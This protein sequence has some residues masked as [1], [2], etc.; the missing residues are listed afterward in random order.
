MTSK[1]YTGNIIT[2]TPTDPTGNSGAN[3]GVATGVWSLS[4]ARTFSAAG[5]WPIPASVPGAP[6]IGTATAGNATATVPFT[7]N[8]D[9]GGL[10]VT[11][12]T[13]TSNPG[14]ITGSASS[15]PITVTGLTNE[16][17]YT[18][19]VTATNAAGTSAASAASNSVT[20]ENPDRAVF[21][22]GQIL[23]GSYATNTMDYIDIKST[24]NATDFGD[25]SQVRGGGGAASSTTRALCMGGGD[26]FGASGSTNY[27]N[28][29]DYVTIATTG[30]SS[31][32]GSLSASIRTQ[33]GGLSNSTR[34]C[35]MFGWQSNSIAKQ[36]ID[37]VAIAT[38]GNAADFGD[39]DNGYYDSAAAF[40]SSTRGLMCGGADY[41]S[42]YQNKIQYITIATTGDATDFGDLRSGYGRIGGTSSSTRGIITGWTGAN[43]GTGSGQ[44]E[45]VTISS[46]GN[47]TAFGDLINAGSN[48]SY[49]CS[50]TSNNTTAVIHEGY[51]NS[52]GGTNVLSYVTI[53]STGNASD[54]GD[55]TVARY[56]STATSGTHGGLQ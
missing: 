13:A 54:F 9:D 56:M 10:D 28:R 38:T 53:A 35:Q 55:L 51:N 5:D 14:S 29:I 42:S 11:S 48:K 41:Y 33:C 20:P 37:Y 4:E 47:A 8:A 50:A 36:Q 26:V 44:L 31:I 49:Y 7:A 16:T 27:S 22:A 6:T 19:T 32:F 46:T 3:Y 40:A 45:Y 15:S 18:F 30:N 39:L 12:F 43:S 34:A 24:G 1:R 52:A 23:G 17:A 21:M 2:D 25:L